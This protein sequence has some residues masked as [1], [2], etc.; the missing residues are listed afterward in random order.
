MQRS[1]ADWKPIQGKP[2]GKGRDE[3]G[4]MTQLTWQ[5]DRQHLY[6]ALSC[7]GQSIAWRL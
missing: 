5:G 6:V 3:A 7:P 4:G 1:I 2:S